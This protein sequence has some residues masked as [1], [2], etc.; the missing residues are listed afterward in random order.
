MKMRD[1]ILVEARRLTV[2]EGQIPSLNAVAAAAE[3]SKGGLIHHF[4]SREALI[5]GLGRQA[6]D[7]IDSAMRDAAARGQAARAWL[8]LC[9]PGDPEREL[10]RA[11]VTAFQATHMGLESLVADAA[12]MTI[13]WERMI[14]DE[15]GD[16]RLARVVRL[17]GDGLTANAMLS[18][19][20][21]TDADD[22]DTLLSVILEPP[23]A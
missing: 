14:A 16:P 12:A 8:Q 19:E 2:S 10:Y 18:P 4:P 9:I 15:V 21:S 17:V 23:R 13:A 22:I 1:R 5:E 20:L 3:V 11:L 7:E 6:L